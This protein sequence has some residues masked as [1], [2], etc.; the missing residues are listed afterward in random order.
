MSVIVYL[1]TFIGAIAIVGISGYIFE[2]EVLGEAAL[3]VKNFSLAAL[4]CVLYVLMIPAFVVFR[5]VSYM[6]FIE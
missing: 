1:L 4:K 3:K 2:S 6:G 5:A